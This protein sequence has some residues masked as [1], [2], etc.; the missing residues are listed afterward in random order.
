MGVLKTV[1]LMSRRRGY[2]M[3]FQRGISVREASHVRAIYSK[4][5]SYLEKNVANTL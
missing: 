4:K 1:F 3:M 5:H 2:L